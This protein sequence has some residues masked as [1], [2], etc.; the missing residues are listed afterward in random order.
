MPT[1]KLYENNQTVVPSEIRKIYDLKPDDII[2]WII[3]EN[4]KPELEF[5]KKSTLKDIIG[6]AT[7]KEPF[8]SVEL[9]KKIERG[10][11]I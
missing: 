7:A 5:R 6:K 11:E 2:E 9:Q 4:G 8:N 3:N 1:T 10:E